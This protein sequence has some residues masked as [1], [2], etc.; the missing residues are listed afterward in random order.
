MSEDENIHDRSVVPIITFLRE[1]FAASPD[2]RFLYVQGVDGAS[3]TSKIAIHG[4]E[5]FNPAQAELRPG[6][7]VERDEAS[8]RNATMNDNLVDKV[9]DGS[10][11]V[12]ADFSTGRVICHCYSKSKLVSSHLGSLV[13]ELVH[14]FKAEIRLMGYHDIDS[15]SLA[16]TARYRGKDG[17]GPEF[18]S[19]AV[20]LKIVLKQHATK[21][22]IPEEDA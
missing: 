11:Q 9:G 22:Q 20:V 3:D 21:T 19:T 2:P 7:S 15:V 14:Y 1:L 8:W 6:I 10:K 18:R 4:D 12:L 16:K 5:T 17:A 13:Y